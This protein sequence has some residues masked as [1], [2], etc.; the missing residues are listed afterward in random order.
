MPISLPD[1]LRPY[2]DR[3][4]DFAFPVTIADTDQPD[5]PIIWANPAFFHLTGYP[6]AEVIGRNCRFLQPTPGC[7]HARAAVRAAIADGTS[8]DVLLQN[9]RRDG[10]L[11]INHLLIRPLAPESG[12]VIGAQ[13]DVSA[14]VTINTA[15]DGPAYQFLIDPP[16]IADRIQ[17]HRAGILARWVSLLN[18][19]AVAAR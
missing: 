3:L 7:P 6:L 12:L 19:S 14:T 1:R 11:F 18:A 17:A 9:A 15:P 5:C 4:D 10:T 16:D 8:T 2:R 13:Y